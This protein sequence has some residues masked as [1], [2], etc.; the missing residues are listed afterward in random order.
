MS[1][2]SFYNNRDSDHK[3]SNHIGSHSLIN[4]GHQAGLGSNMG[5][6]YSKYPVN[7]YEGDY[8][9]YSKTYETPDDDSYSLSTQ[10]TSIPSRGYSSSNNKADPSFNSYSSGSFQKNSDFG[11]YAA[12]SNSNSQRIPSYPGY[13]S[14]PAVMLEN[15]AEGTVDS[16]THTQGY[17]GASGTP[18][19]SESDQVYPPY[20]SVDPAGEYLFGKQKGGPYGSLKGGNR[21]N[22]IHS[23]PSEMRYTRGNAG[24]AS[25]N[26][27][28]SSPYLSGSG[29]GGYLSKAYGSSVY[30]SAGK[31]YKYGYKYLSRYAPNSGV[32]YTRERDSHYATPYYGKPGG[33][34]IIIKDNRPSY[35]NLYPDE[36]SYMNGYRSKSGGLMGAASYPALPNIDIYEGSTLPRRYRATNGPTVVQKTVYSP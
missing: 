5:D 20:P 26:H 21:Y 27:G 34:V 17:H 33:K 8:S 4:G 25:Y 18:S 2:G 35:M 31:P 24:Q 7:D 10:A 11:Q 9:G 29:P 22:N 23:M 30:S 28:V 13:T 6:S 3:L 15:Y 16:E 1:G 36:P 32:T 19:Y 12:G 14:R